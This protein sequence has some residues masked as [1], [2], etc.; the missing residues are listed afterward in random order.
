MFDKPGVFYSYDPKIVFN[1]EW[2]LDNN[3]IQSLTQHKISV[4]DFSSEHY[5]DDGLDHVY[6][7]LENASINFL[8]L[9]HNP[10]DHLKFD[11]MLFYPH[12]YHW[13]RQNFII[14]ENNSNSRSY[15]WSCLNGNPRPHRV[16]NY[17][18]S[19]QQSYYQSA[20]FTFYN[21]DP[22]RADDVIL[23]QDVTNFWKSVRHTL[24]NRSNIHV[25]SR[26]D[27]RCDLPANNDAYIHLVTETTVI[28][29]IFVSEKTWKPVAAGQIFLVFGNPGTISYLRD[30]GVDVFDD[31]VD[32][33]YDSI[34]NWQDRLHAIHHQLKHLLSQDL[35]SVFEVT[36]ARR[37]NNV[38]KFFSGDFDC[39]YKNTIDQIIE[40]HT[41]LRIS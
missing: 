12:W 18:Y 23:P 21:E 19:Q 38:K 3:K 41:N 34:D 8:L 11:R 2:L 25:G 7:A 6:S 13:S 4:L 20:Y 15:K 1:N 9:T 28:P 22:V 40:H 36:K 35:E 17:F 39:R 33:S 30:Q 31:I 5:G 26:P 10:A 14:K 29:R 16:Y 24:P 37:T 32:H 27:S